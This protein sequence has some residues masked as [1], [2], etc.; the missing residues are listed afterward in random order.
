MSAHPIDPRA[1]EAAV[2]ALGVRCTVESRAGL[3]LLIPVGDDG[4]LENA[5]TRQ[6][7]LTTLRGYG[8]THAAV[9]LR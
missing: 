8:F 4:S 9:E 5:E 2:Q 1:A 7:V 6:R 3:A